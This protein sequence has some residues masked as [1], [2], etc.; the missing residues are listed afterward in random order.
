MNLAKTLAL[1]GKKVCMLDLDLRR[2]SLSNHF[3]LLKKEGVVEYLMN[4]NLNI[5]SMLCDVDEECNLKMLPAGHL[6]LN[7][8]ELLMGNCFDEMMKQLREKFDYILIDNPPLNIVADTKITNRCTD[9]TIYIIRAGVL[10]RKDVRIV[11]D[12]YIS[13]TLKNM[14]VVLTDVDYERLYYSLGYKGYGKAYGTKYAV[15]KYYN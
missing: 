13:E 1:A 9:L 4:K 2:R 5:E 7:P 15:G 8:A 11:E 12:I 6:C 14:G 10:D 3:L